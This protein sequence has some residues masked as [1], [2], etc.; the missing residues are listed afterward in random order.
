MHKYA[1]NDPQ[2]HFIVHMFQPVSY[3]RSIPQDFVFQK[4]ILPH[5]FIGH[6][7]ETHILGLSNG[8]DIWIEVIMHDIH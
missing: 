5:E 1:L 8:D 4:M 3:D 7:Y 2:K 6:V